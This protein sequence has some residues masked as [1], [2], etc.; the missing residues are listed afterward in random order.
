MPPESRG[1]PRAPGCAAAPR[2]Q[3]K[4]G[5]AGTMTRKLPSPPEGTGLLPLPL[6]GEGRGEG[7]PALASVLRNCAPIA[8]AVSG[9]V[10]SLTLATL[11]HRELGE[12]AAMYH[13]VSPAVPAEATARTKA[14]AAAE[15]WA[16]HVIEAGE[17]ADPDYRR[18]PASRCFFCKT[19]LYA[20][21][22]TRTDRRIVS[23]TN[24]DDLG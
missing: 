9:G 8:V 7:L 14:L 10:D 18:N 21:I 4:L 2:T 19:N 20:A 22:T 1:T 23:G 6:A 13:A 11:A 3:P 12:R 15:G 16:L 17:F 24:L 5:R